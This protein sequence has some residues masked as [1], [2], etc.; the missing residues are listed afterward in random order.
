MADKKQFETEVAN[1][2]KRRTAEL[3]ESKNQNETML[4]QQEQLRKKIDD[5]TARNAEKDGEIEVLQKAND[6]SDAK[7]AEL[8]KRYADTKADTE[9]NQNELEQVASKMRSRNQTLVEKL[10]TR[11]E[12]FETIEKQNAAFTEKLALL[13][14]K[15]ESF[16]NQLSLMS[17]KPNE[18]ATENDRLKSLVSSMKE[19]SQTLAKSNEDLNR[20]INKLA[21]KSQELQANNDLLTAEVLKL[22]AKIKSSESDREP[23][24]SNS[25]GSRPSGD[26]DR[27][28]SEDIFEGDSGKGLSLLNSEQKHKGTTE[29][30][31]VGSEM[32]FAV[33][34]PTKPNE[35]TGLAAGFTSGSDVAANSVD[36]AN[37]T[38]GFTA[39]PDAMTHSADDSY[40]AA[41]SDAAILTTNDANKSEGTWQKYIEM[42]GVV[43]GFIALTLL[44]LVFA[45]RWSLRS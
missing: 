3:T 35:A 41:D 16:S 25:D 5:F 23:S 32:G 45:L 17:E 43:P 4:K 11:N 37:E 26:R 29:S 30:E 36:R 28:S 40:D 24:S 13:T 8:K 27:S 42:Y 12:E 6:S 44:L 7:F 14:A 34:N 39:N 9:K 1:D 2:S 31:H 21:A 19:Q 22:K 18:I 38:S 15:N 20:Q 10:Q 33:S